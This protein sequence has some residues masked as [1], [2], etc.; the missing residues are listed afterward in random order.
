MYRKRKYSYGHTYKK[1]DQIKI[2]KKRDCKVSRGWETVM[3]EKLKKR[4]AK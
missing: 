3:T 4:M 1:W 2:C